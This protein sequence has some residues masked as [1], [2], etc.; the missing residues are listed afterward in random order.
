[1]ITKRFYSLCA[2]DY[3]KSIDFLKNL[4]SIKVSKSLA[5]TSCYSNY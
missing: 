2:L 4:V 1:M 5:F 3:R